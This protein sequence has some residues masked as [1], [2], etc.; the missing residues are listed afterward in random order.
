MAQTP[1]TERPDV[2]YPD[3]PAGWQWASGEGGGRHYTRWFQTAYR[4]GGSLVG[5][6]GF[7]GY[8]GQVYWDKG[9]DHVVQITPITHPGP[10]DG[11]PEYGYPVRTRHYDSEQAAVDAVPGLIAGLAEDRQ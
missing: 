10:K 4:M 9:S 11:D 8:D 3:L 5:V 1:T 2:T 6:H 7:G